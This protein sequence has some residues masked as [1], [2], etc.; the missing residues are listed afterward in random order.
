VHKE[1]LA[2][3]DVFSMFEQAAGD[4]SDCGQVWPCV[5][6]SRPDGPGVGARM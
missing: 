2:V 4:R 3:L 1:R 6:A 5:R